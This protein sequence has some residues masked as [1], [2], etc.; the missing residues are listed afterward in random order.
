VTIADDARLRS[1]AAATADWPFT[2]WNFGEAIALDALLEASLHLNE[3]VYEQHVAALCLASIAKGVGRVAED[4]Q[5]PG[6]AFVT[7]YR[8]RGDPRYLAAAEALAVLH[9]RLPRN[10]QGAIL[11]RAHQA[12]WKH[13]IWIDSIDLI[14]PLY[15]NLANVT[16]DPV[17]QRQAV[18]LTLAHLRC[19]QADSGLACHGY[20]THSGRNGHHWSR[21]MGWA[22]MGMADV[23]VLTPETTP[24]RDEVLQRFVAMTQALLPLQRDDGLWHIVVDRPDSYPETTLAAMFVIAMQ[25]AR[26]AGWITAD[27][28]TAPMAAARQGVLHHVDPRGALERVS[29]ATAIGQYATYATRPFGQFPWGQGPLLMMECMS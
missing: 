16:D 21:G 1:I 7:L 25:K 26:L 10:P 5:A 24:G 20:D 22:L 27:S 9:D 15:A 3:P 18:D 17:R 12:G 14:G 11:V 4:C 19:L 6:R 28:L 2:L 29:D 13:Q 23:L 8:R